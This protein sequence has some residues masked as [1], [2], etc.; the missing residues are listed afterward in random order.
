M[1]GRTRRDKAT[2]RATVA[3][4][5]RTQAAVDRIVA[6]HST[7]ERYVTIARARTGRSEGRSL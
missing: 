7:A 5:P 3:L 6:E 2:T 1:F 4:D